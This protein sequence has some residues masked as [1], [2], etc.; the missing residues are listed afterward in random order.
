MALL[1]Q[2]QQRFNS[3]SITFFVG[4]ARSGRSVL[5][6]CR[7]PA[8]PMLPASGVNASCMAV[9]CVSSVL[10][11]LSHR[12]KCRRSARSSSSIGRNR[13]QH[14]SG[15]IVHVSGALFGNA[16]YKSPL[17]SSSAFRRASGTHASNKNPTITT[18]V[19]FFMPSALHPVVCP[20]CWNRRRINV[21]IGW[22][23]FAH[24]PMVATV[25]S[26]W[27]GFQTRAKIWASRFTATKKPDD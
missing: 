20:H 7:R 3:T 8:V 16:A 6:E 19:G 21:H 5:S 2:L 15:T 13:V 22:V 25:Q 24:A 27:G 18:T 9:L 26:V 12:S 17:I 23:S 4:G 14:V 10:T 1:Q 11:F